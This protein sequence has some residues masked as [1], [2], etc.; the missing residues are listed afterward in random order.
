[1]FG[2]YISLGDTAAL[3]IY[4]VAAYSKKIKDLF[5]YNGI[6]IARLGQVSTFR[7]IDGMF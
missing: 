6:L 4:I 1:M 2:V 7:P 5:L 3:F